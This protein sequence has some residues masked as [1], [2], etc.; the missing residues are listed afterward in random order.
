MLAVKWYYSDNGL[1]QNYDDIFVVTQLPWKCCT[2]TILW[3]GFD[4]IFDKEDSN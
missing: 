4:N 1:D 2:A 3:S